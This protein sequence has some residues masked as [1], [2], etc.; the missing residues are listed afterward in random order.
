[1]CLWDY[2]QF[3]AWFAQKA[4]YCAARLVVSFMRTGGGDCQFKAWYAQKAA[5]FAA[6][7]SVS[8][9][10]TSSAGTVAKAGEGVS[11]LTADMRANRESICFLFKTRLLYSALFTF[12]FCLKVMN[13]CRDPPLPLLLQSAMKPWGA[14]VHLLYDQFYIDSDS[15]I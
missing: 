15:S 5:Y 6:R 8:F 13:F 4:A 10:R 12:N 11:E 7:S 3:K 1:M 2:C 9:M 14:P